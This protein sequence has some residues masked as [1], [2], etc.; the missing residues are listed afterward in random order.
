[1]LLLSF[2][3]TE[4]YSK[5]YSHAGVVNL[6]VAVAAVGSVVGDF[7]A[8][9][10]VDSADIVVAVVD[11]TAAVAIVWIVDV[12]VCT[13]VVV[14]AGPT[15][16][17]AREALDVVACSGGVGVVDVVATVNL[18]V[19]DDVGIVV[20]SADAAD[21]ADAV[22][23]VSAV[24]APFVDVAENI[25]ADGIVVVVVATLAVDSRF[26]VLVY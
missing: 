6:V 15:V 25:A 7:V 16:A 26:V 22:A 23:V 18:V 13:R 4:K 20:D 8:V 11:Q 19:V 2:L 12:V 17:A 5:G 1:M 10:D 24:G 14:L 21:T 3:L 9:G